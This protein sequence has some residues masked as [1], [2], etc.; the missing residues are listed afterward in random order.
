MEYTLRLKPGMGSH[1]SNSRNEFRYEVVEAQSVHG[2]FTPCLICRTSF[3]HSKSARLAIPPWPLLLEKIA[4][5]SLKVP[6]KLRC[7]SAE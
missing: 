3:F 4:L 6:T 7:F 5:F 1:L 2:L